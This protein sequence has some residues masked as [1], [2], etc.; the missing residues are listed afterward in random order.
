MHRTTMTSATI[1]LG[2]VVASG[3]TVSYRSR[4]RPVVR[5]EASFTVPQYV[6]VTSRPPAPQAAVVERPAAPDQSAVWVPGHYEHPQGGWVWV[7][8]HWEAG[9]AGEKWIDPVV[10]QED[11]RDVYYP[12]YW[13]PEDQP[14][15]APYQRPGAVVVAAHHPHGGTRVEP[16]RQGGGTPVEPTR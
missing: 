16:T 1:A 3:C 6:V 2:L 11:G 15:A 9:H 13:C 12:G 5:A 14:P 10:V 7:D 4:A 8:G